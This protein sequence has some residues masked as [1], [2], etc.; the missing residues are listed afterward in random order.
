MVVPMPRSEA[1]AEARSSTARLAMR[2]ASATCAVDARWPG[3]GR[4]ASRNVRR[5]SWL[6]TSPAAWPP[7]P[8]ATTHSGRSASTLSWFTGR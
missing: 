7:M 1:S 2:T 3:A 4:A 5:A 8:S 6:A